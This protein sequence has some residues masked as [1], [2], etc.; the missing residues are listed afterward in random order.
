MDFYIS[1]KKGVLRGF[2]GLHFVCVVSI[3]AGLEVCLKVEGDVHVSVK[4]GNTESLES[5]TWENV[6]W[7]SFCWR[8]QRTKLVKAEGVTNMFEVHSGLVNGMAKRW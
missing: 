8:T 7:I 5:D 2:E 4:D 6:E 1:L 3:G